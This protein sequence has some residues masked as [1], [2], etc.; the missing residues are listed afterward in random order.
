MNHNLKGIGVSSE[1]N[2][3]LFKSEDANAVMRFI[4]MKTLMEKGLVQKEEFDAR[5]EKI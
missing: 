2:P 5:R 4:V 3:E 1:L